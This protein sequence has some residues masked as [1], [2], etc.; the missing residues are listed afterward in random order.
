MQALK[1]QSNPTA[2]TATLRSLD[3]TIS[4]GKF[5]APADLSA[6]EKRWFCFFAVL[7]GFGYRNLQAFQG[8]IADSE[9][10]CN[11]LAGS[12]RATCYRALKDLESRGWIRRSRH[13]RGREMRIEFLE[14]MIDIITGPRLR[15][16]PNMSD[17]NLHVSSC[18]TSD[19]SIIPT[20]SDPLVCCF[21]SS[22]SSRAGAREAGN[23][24][25]KNKDDTGGN[26]HRFDPIVYTI[27][28]LAERKYRAV[29]CRMAQLEMNGRIPNRSGVDWPYWRPMWQTLPIST[30]E[31]I[32]ASTIIPALLDL[33][34]NPP[35]PIRQI[36]R[37]KLAEIEST[38]IVREIGKRRSLFEEEP[39]EDPDLALLWWARKNAQDS[40]RRLDGHPEQTRNHVITEQP[41]PPHVPAENTD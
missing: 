36:E 5:R 4:I 20:P 18:D 1:L 28:C 41:P 12:S 2:T 40:L 9:S 10:R 14:P 32:A 11:G 23:S 25:E 13:F 35:P 22:E 15:A 33:I 37:E 38:R 16:V 19:P 3:Y 26:G 6:R 7:I 31:Y 27:R 8:A 21:N 24:I 29:L 17:K 39:P 34:K 30:R